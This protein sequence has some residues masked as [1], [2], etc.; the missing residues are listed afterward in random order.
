V[1]VGGEI[2]ETKATVRKEREKNKEKRRIQ[3][4]TKDCQFLDSSFLFFISPAAYYLLGRLP[5]VIKLVFHE[6]LTSEDLPVASPK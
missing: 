6:T 1:R 3:I 5:L 4:K 2:P